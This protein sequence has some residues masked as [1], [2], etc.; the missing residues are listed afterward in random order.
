[1]KKEEIKISENKAPWKWWCCH[2]SCLNVCL[3][4]PYLD[5]KVHEAEEDSPLFDTSTIPS[6]KYISVYDWLLIPPRTRWIR[7]NATWSEAKASGLINRTL[8]RLSHPFL[9][10]GL[11]QQV[12]TS[13]PSLKQEHQKTWA[14]VLTMKVPHLCKLWQCLLSFHLWE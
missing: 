11:V 13:C 3:L 9:A 10:I 6:E 14:Q 1:M 12:G 5:C 7:G 8:G 4:A 2:Y